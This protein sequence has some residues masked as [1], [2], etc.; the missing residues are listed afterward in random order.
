MIVDSGELQLLDWMPRENLDKAIVDAAR[1]SYGD[2]TKTT[3]D[4]RA[5]IRFLMRHGH[6]SPF[7]MVELKWRVKAPIF[8]ARQWVRHRTA[9]WNEVSARYSD[10][11]EVEFYEPDLRRQSGSNKQCS[12]EELVGGSKELLAQ[13]AIAID[14]CSAS[15]DAQLAAGVSRE[16]A[17]TVLPVS[18]FTEWV[19]KCDLHN[20]LRFLR[21]RMHPHAQHEIRVFANAIFSTLE[22]LCPITME[23]FKDFQLN[24]I[25]LTRLEVE[26]LRS[27]SV[28]NVDLLGPSATKREQDEWMAKR[29]DLFVRSNQ[30]SVH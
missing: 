13:R 19:W 7:E 23:A 1:V 16:V 18:M 29:K 8:V 12:T 25:T 28:N 17:R 22:E 5:L 20:T 27:S 2:G 4:D 21:Q 10:M 3:S 26:A 14:G 15:Y 6:T 30:P 9:S 11:S 24:A